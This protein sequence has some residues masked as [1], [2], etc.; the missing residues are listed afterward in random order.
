[1]FSQLKSFTTDTTLTERVMETFRCMKKEQKTLKSI[2]LKFQQAKN[3]ITSWQVWWWAS[4]SIWEEMKLLLRLLWELGPTERMGTV[5]ICS[6]QFMSGILQYIVPMPLREGVECPHVIRKCSVEP[7]EPLVC[8]L[9]SYVTETALT[10]KVMETNVLNF[11]PPKS[12]F[13]ISISI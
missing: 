9:K 4:T 12:C 11:Y 8:F 3:A 7:A 1:M 6:H 2:R 5:G 10:E 13:K